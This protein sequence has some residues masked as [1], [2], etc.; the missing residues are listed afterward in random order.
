MAASA[1]ILFPSAALLL[2]PLTAW[3]Q[4]PAPQPPAAA[5]QALRA[6]V[7]EFLQDFVDG[8]YRK[9]LKFVAE[10]SQDLYFGSAKAELKNFKIDDIKYDD[11]FQ[12]ATVFFTTDRS[13]KVHFEGLTEVPIT[14][15]MSSTWKIED[16]QWVWYYRANE[17]WITPMGASNAE[18]ISR[19]VDGTVT[20]PKVINQDTADAAATSILQQSKVDKHSVTL[21]SDKASSDKVVFHNAINGQVTAELIDV[22]SVPGLSIKLN[23]TSLNF[24]EE[25]V[26][27]I[28]YNPPDDQDPDFQMPSRVFGLSVHPF[29]Q[30]FVIEINFRPAA[31]Q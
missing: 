20:V 8:Q 2:L 7:S 3:T 30:V 17:P 6:R 11:T 13:W 24:D 18:L 29:E 9:A 31:K 15:Q 14:V 22:P 25:A 28:S 10:E 27:D 19:K 12:N 1:R 21:L 26:A 4:A 5:D 23:K 16:G